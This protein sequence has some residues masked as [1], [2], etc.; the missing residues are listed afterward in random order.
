MIKVIANLRYLHKEA[1]AAKREEPIEKQSYCDGL[2]DGLSEAIRI[3]T[4]DPKHVDFILIKLQEY[5]EH[6]TLM[7]TGYA[8]SY[9]EGKAWALELARKEAAR[10]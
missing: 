2:I 8:R 5:G 3:C 4:S 10:R 9:Y 1:I 7:T 6:T